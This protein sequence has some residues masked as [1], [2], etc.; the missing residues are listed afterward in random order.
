MSIETKKGPIGF[1]TWIACGFG[2]GF[3]PLAPGS[4]ATLFLV[5]LA[6]ALRGTLESEGLLAIVILVMIVVGIPLCNAAEKQLGHDAQS[7]VWDEFVGFAVAIWFLPELTWETIVGAFLA[8]R[9]FDVLKPFPVNRAEKL[10]R[11]WGIIGDDF[12]AGVYANLVERRVWK[13]LP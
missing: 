8:F 6:G 5:F 13:L 12:L 3:A 11:G 1:A 2:L 9:F 4:I 7:I 10:P